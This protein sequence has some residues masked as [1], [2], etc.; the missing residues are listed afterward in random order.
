MMGQGRRASARGHLLEDLGAL[1]F[2]HPLGPFLGAF[3]GLL[4]K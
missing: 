1:I 4:A 2:L 3:L